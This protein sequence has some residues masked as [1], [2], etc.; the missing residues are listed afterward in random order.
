[1]KNSK[2]IEEIT[3]EDVN[4]VLQLNKVVDF[5]TGTL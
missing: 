3:F 5:E 1:M 2:F 4:L